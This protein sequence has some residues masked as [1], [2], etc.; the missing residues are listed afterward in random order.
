MTLTIDAKTRLGDEVAAVAT[1]E[2]RDSGH[3]P[4][5]CNGRFLKPQIDIEAGAVWQYFQA[6][7]IES[8]MGGER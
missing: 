1:A 2:L 8:G 3:M 4:I 6:V 7:E 5:R